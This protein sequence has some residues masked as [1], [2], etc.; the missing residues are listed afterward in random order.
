MTDATS[1]LLSERHG[2]VLTLTFNRPEARNPLSESMIAA[3]TAAI[4]G[5]AHDGSVAAVVLAANG[6]AFCAGHDLKEMT[7]RRA[8]ADRGLSRVRSRL[9]PPSRALPRRRDVSWLRRA[10]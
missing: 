7:A 4:N 2:A 1:L 9:L 6:P 3:L 10:I 8:D 5:A